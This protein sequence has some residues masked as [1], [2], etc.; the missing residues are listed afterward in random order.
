MIKKRMPPLRQVRFCCE[1][2]K[3]RRVAEQGDAL[4]SF[5]VR[6]AESTRRAANRDE[7]EI[8]KNGRHG[9]KIIMPYDNDDNRRTFEVCYADRE[10]RVNPIA[11]WSN[12][13]LWNYSHEAKLE[14]CGLYS[15]GFERLGCIGCPQARECG[16]RHEFER[17]P[18]F[19]KLWRWAF[20]RILEERE[21]LGMIKLSHAL[22][23]D[24]WFEWWLTDKA[25]EAPV[26]G[27]QLS[28]EGDLYHID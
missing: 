22:D 4:L 23:P 7:L 11:M 17:W 5:G 24:A 14:Q 8:G 12:E 10:K 1:Y 18:R 15:E 6:K 27:N 19:E 26:D 2:L 3:E 20:R 25:Q 9:E 16:R 28:M 13:D 21:R